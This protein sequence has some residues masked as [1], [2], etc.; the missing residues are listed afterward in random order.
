MTFILFI[1]AEKKVK[2]KMLPVNIHCATFHQSYAT[3]RENSATF[4][5]FEGMLPKIG[6]MLPKIGGTFSF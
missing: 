4:R 5:E 3:F 2:K 6:G 1:V